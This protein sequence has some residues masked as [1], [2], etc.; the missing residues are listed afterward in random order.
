MGIIV[1]RV[2]APVETVDRRPGS[3]R[4]LSTADAAF[5]PVVVVPNE[6][7]LRS[8]EVLPTVTTVAQ[9]TRSFGTSTQGPDSAATS[10]SIVSAPFTLGTP[11]SSIPKPPPGRF[12][13]PE[14]RQT[15]TAAGNAP[16]VV[17]DGIGPG[18][19]PSPP[20]LRA[21][22]PPPVPRPLPA[23]TTALAPALA[24]SRIHTYP[25]RSTGA[26]LWELH[27]CNVRPP[28]ATRR[29]HY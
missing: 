2:P 6:D 8:A 10:G 17:E 23:P 21:H 4:S 1:A 7:A 26:S 18:G 24:A 16:A 25:S 14:R 27:C 22:T 9:P 19:F 12:S 11:A 28:V 15:T 29:P 3:G 5:S 13:T 20:N